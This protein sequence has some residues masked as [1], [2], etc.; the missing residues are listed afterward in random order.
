[1]ADRG[2]VIAHNVYHYYPAHDSSP[3]YFLYAD[4]INGGSSLEGM[5]AP[6]TEADEQVLHEF[7]CRLNRS[8][9]HKR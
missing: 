5:W 9:Q 7:L 2:E 6:L 3:G 1:M 8:M 4:V